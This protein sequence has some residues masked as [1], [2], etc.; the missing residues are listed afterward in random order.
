MDANNV[1]E[2][3]D[4]VYMYVIS[5][6]NIDLVPLLIFFI[7]YEPSRDRIRRTLINVITKIL[8]DLFVFMHNNIF[9]ENEALRRIIN[10]EICYKSLIDNEEYRLQINVEQNKW[11][12][13]QGNNVVEKGNLPIDIVRLGI[14]VYT[15]DMVVLANVVSQYRQFVECFI[16]ETTDIIN[17]KE[18]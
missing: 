6:L 4:N 7:E 13:K 16:D 14:P 9:I 5:L 11:E 18:G 17:N 8:I 3:V 1:L 2:S 15:R 12:L 10:K